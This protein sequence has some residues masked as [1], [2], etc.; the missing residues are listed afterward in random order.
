MYFFLQTAAVVRE[1][2]VSLALRGG[3]GGGGGGAAR[4]LLAAWGGALGAHGPQH[5][6]PPLTALLHAFSDAPTQAKK[7]A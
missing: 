7:V 6:L 4:A 1:A 3:G 2:L 5:A